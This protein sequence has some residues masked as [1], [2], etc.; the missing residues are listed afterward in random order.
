MTCHQEF[1]LITLIAFVLIICLIRDWILF[2][3]YCSHIAK[4]ESREDEFYSLTAP[5]GGM[6]WFEIEQ[7]AKLWQRHYLK[8][9]DQYLLSMGNT[10]FRRGFF[11]L[12]LMIL[13]I[14]NILFVKTVGC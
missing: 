11:N 13:F 7:V 12:A 4:L 8:F 1:I 5:E 3:K 10:L 9:D 14:V 6:N 2:N